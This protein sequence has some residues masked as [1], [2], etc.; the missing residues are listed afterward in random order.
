MSIVSLFTSAIPHTF[1]ELTGLKNKE[2]EKY[3]SHVPLLMQ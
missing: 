3:S 2:T 1:E